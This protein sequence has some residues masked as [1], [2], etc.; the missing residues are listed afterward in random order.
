MRHGGMNNGE[1]F[2]SFGQFEAANISRRKITATQT[3]GAILGLMETI[4]PQEPSG[5]LR[6]PNAYRLTYVPAKGCA[7]P[8]DEWKKVD[9]DR[10]TK[11]IDAFHNAERAEVKS[12]KSRQKRAA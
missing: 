9:E 6:G 12:R 10:A 11:M 3:L 8:T 7:A 4:R 1:L 2:V 5:D